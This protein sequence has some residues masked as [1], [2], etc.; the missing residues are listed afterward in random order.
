MGERGR[1]N[2]VIGLM[3]IFSYF[4]IYAFLGN[5][6]IVSSLGGLPLIDCTTS[7]IRQ[8]FSGE[9]FATLTKDFAQTIIVVFVVVFVQNIIPRGN[10]NGFRGIIIR[11]IGYIV[12]YL[13]SMWFVRYIVFSSRM[14]DILQMFIAIFSVVFA[15]LGAAF[16]TPLRNIVMRYLSSD[17]L[18]NYLA[19]TRI[20]R[21]L[22]DSFF[23]S[24]VILFLAVAIEMTVGLPY[25]F[26]AVVAGLPAV[27]VLVVTIVLMYIIFRI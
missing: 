16:S 7:L 14:N 5:T 18:R 17:F 19:E 25:F 1:D 9:T 27:I 4:F 3:V 21:W 26:S 2:I 24:T 8:G 10:S 12:L 23:I 13:I 6:A 20:V 15:G 11:I 22:A